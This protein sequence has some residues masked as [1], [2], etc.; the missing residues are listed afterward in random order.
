MK[1]WETATGI[2][3]PILT[4]LS[5]A[6][7]RVCFSPDGKRVIAQDDKGEVRSWDAATGQAIVPCTDPAPALG[8]RDVLS[9]DGA[10]RAASSTR[11]TSAF[12]V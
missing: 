7:T 12:K 8:N 3:L 9:P 11:T 2:E 4:G 1:V 5:S 6:V 10:I